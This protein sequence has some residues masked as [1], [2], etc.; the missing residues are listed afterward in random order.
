[1]FV[2]AMFAQADV[3]ISSRCEQQAGHN[4][5][6]WRI[7]QSKGPASNSCRVC[8]AVVMAARQ[9]AGY[10]LLPVRGESSNTMKLTS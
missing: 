6:R 2:Q 8:Q 7:Q 5:T 4:W 9:A 10:P 3:S 1:M